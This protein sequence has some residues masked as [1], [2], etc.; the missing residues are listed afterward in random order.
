MDAGP[1]HPF[2]AAYGLI[3]RLLFAGTSR[4]TGCMA[5]VLVAPSIITLP[6]RFHVHLP[7]HYQLA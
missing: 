7:G 2:F 4:I 1:L 6:C 5:F 3:K